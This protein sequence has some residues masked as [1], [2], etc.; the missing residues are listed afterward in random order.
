LERVAAESF[1]STPF[2]PVHPRH[3]HPGHACD[4]SRHG[5]GS[6]SRSSMTLLLI[7]FGRPPSLAA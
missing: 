6:W 4:T 3:M 7:G 1:L 2:D 5:S